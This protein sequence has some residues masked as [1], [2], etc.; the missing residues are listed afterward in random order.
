MNKVLKQRPKKIKIL[1]TGSEGFIGH[2]LINYFGPEN[3]VISYDL[4]SQNNILD[5]YNLLTKAQKVNVVI[6]LAA[7][8]GVSF[9]NDNPYYYYRNNVEGTATVARICSNLKIPLLFTSTGDVKMLNSHYSASKLA[10]E[11]VL[12]AERKAKGLSYKI[13][14]FLQV[15]GP[16]SPENY[17]IPIF[18][19]KCLN[20]DPIELHGG[21]LQKKDFTHV[22]DIAKTIA[23][24]ATEK[25]DTDRTVTIGTG[26]KTSIA[27]VASLV[28]KLTRSKSKII[29][30][31]EKRKGEIMELETDNFYKISDYINIEAGIKGIL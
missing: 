19:R 18:I 7:A 20:N 28:K 5:Y 23:K 17:V 31:E 22:F 14:R 1:I 12:E 11:H 10:A 6:H 21:G 16:G 25:I 3:D 29:E 15:Y 24:F 13:I 9:S 26:I 2:N 8:T 4:Q 30:V 27:K